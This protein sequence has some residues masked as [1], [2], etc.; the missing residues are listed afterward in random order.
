MRAEIV[1]VFLS[2][3]LV[4]CLAW[5]KSLLNVCWTELNCTGSNDIEANKSEPQYK[6]AY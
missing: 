1:L 4:Q 2:L 3:Y 5:S 6:L